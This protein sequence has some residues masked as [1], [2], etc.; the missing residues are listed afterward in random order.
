MAGPDQPAGGS[1][2]YSPYL[3]AAVGG[4]AGGARRVLKNANAFAVFD[5]FGHAQANGPVAEGLFFEDTRYLSRFVVTIDGRQPRL[6]SSIVTEE[7]TLLAVDLSNP[8]LMED[9]RLR[10]PGGTVHLL[11]SMVLGKVALFVSL[12]MHNFGMYPARF[13]LAVDVDSDF[14][15]IFEVRGTPRARRGEMLPAQQHPDG[16]VLSYRGLDG[17]TRRTHIRFDPRPAQAAARHVSWDIRLGPGERRTVR[18]EV[19]CEHSGA[20]PSRVSRAEAVAEQARWRAER[21]ARVAA[22]STRNETFD[23]WLRCSRADLEMLT[24]ETPQGLYPYAGVPWFSTAFGRDGLITALECLWLDPDLAAGTLRFLAANQATE[25]DPAA[26][27]EPGKILHETRSGEMAA[28]GEV[29]F[30]RYYGSIDA[31]PLFVMLAA[32][33]YE[34]T[35]DLALIRSLWPNVEAALAWM[36]DYGDPDRD[37]FIEYCSRSAGGLDNQGW[38]D[39]RDAIFH[40]D[41]RLARAPIALAEVQGYAHAAYLGAAALARAL[42]REA[43][44]AELAA[45]ADSLRERFEAAFWLDEFDT[46]A[47]ALDRDKRPCRVRSSN[48]GQALFG[49]IVRPDRAA[50]TAATLMAPDSFSGWGVR[51]IAADQVRYNP[52]SYHNGSVW[53]HDNALIALG[54]ARYGLRKP[55]LAILQGMFDAAARFQLKRLPELF[56]GFGRRPDLGPTAYPLACAPQAW[57]AAAVFALVGATLG[58]SFVPQERQIRFAAPMLPPWLDEISLSNLRLGDARV[59]LALRRQRDT[60]ALDVLRRD[61]PLDIVLT[62]AEDAP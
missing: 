7:N 49:G 31:T 5:P 15:D 16:S 34:R 44:A 50:R 35:G 41:G 53:P 9:G 1:E 2:V 17:V 36:R 40:A 37:G 62:S 11:N 20:R 19:C 28:L 18:L 3:I 30:G 24:T 51:T 23:D 12:E 47:I 42:G 26:D 13:G 33:Y 22:I 55:L 61:G 59:D 58:I 45:A 4:G 29:P 48:A 46:Y 10:L 21:A 43:R 56:C 38:K 27:A 6:L 54:F 8:D 52:M 39:S 25:L 32:A 14:V 57:S 60:I